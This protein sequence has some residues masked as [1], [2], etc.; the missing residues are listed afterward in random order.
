MDLD[1]AEEALRR[2]REQKFFMLRRMEYA[3][4]LNRPTDHYKFSCSQL[5]EI[6]KTLHTYNDKPFDFS[7]PAYNEIAL[8]LCLYFTGDS[9]FNGDLKKGLALFG[10]VGTGKTALIRAFTNNQVASYRVKSILEITEDYKEN[11]EGA[12][13]HYRANAQG[14]RNHFGLCEYGYC[15]DDIG[16]EEIP[17]QHFGEKKNVFA[18]ILQSRSLYLPLHTTHMTSN[19]DPADMKTLYGSRVADRMTEMFNVITFNG[20]ESFRK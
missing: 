5:Y 20:I 19:I 7:N 10:S 2:A 13:K 1:E 18:E 4:E 11:G 17:A 6:L 3:K 15:F 16:A 14:T 12:I 9:A 8:Q